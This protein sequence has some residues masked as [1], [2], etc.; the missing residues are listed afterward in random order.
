ML[1]F[2]ENCHELA[3]YTVRDEPKEKIIKGNKVEY[4][5]KEAYCKDCGSEIFVADIR[6]HNLSMLDKAY[7][8]W[9]G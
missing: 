7:R 5:G 2:C 8:E 3:E 9:K 4:M 6:D 1:A